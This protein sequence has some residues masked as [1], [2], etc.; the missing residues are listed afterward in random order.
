MLSSLC[1]LPVQAGQICHRE[2][3]PAQFYS[4]VTYCVTSAQLDP[5][6]TT[7]GPANLFWAGQDNAWCSSLHGPDDARDVITIEFDEPVRFR[8]V[9]IGNGHSS[10]DQTFRDSGRVQEM[11]IEAGGLQEV[12]QLADLPQDQKITFSS[13]VD[14]TTITARIVSTYP[15]A[16]YGAVCL[17]E[18]WPDLEEANLY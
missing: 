2:Q 8:T 12:F 14:A 18:I 13:W 4:T 7:H 6:P 5:T 16:R 9:I 10:T 15:G 1:G 11:M 3:G 17:S